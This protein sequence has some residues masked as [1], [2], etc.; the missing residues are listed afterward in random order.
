MLNIS[1][2]TQ[3]NFS[4]DFV[5]FHY[6]LGIISSPH[7]WTYFDDLYV[8]CRVS[9]RR[10]ACW[11]SVD[12]ATHLEGQPPTQNGERESAFSSQTDQNLKLLCATSKRQ[13]QSPW[14]LVTPCG[15]PVFVDDLTFPNVHSGRTETKCQYSPVSQERSE[16]FGPNLVRRY[17]SSFYTTFSTHDY[18]R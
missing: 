13:I 16:I 3:L 18:F 1:K 9:A 7:R 6:S 11:G 10:G 5:L 4:V 2:T 8:K 17:T 12:T 14:N 15:S